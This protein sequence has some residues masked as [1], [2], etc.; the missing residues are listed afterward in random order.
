M[1]CS[2]Y[3]HSYRTHTGYIDVACMVM[4]GLNSSINSNFPWSSGDI[5]TKND[6][7]L[8]IAAT[9]SIFD[10]DLEFNWASLYQMCEAKQCPQACYLWEFE[11]NPTITLWCEYHIAIAHASYVVLSM[12]KT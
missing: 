3:D 12:W 4:I 6:E 5:L 11:H 8:K 10:G 1:R 2:S 7:P 9:T